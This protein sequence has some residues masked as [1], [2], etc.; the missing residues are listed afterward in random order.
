MVMMTGMIW[1][2]R[3]NKVAP[4]GKS[5]ENYNPAKTRSDP[6]RSNREMGA[7]KTST[8]QELRRRSPPS[9]KIVAAQATEAT[10]GAAATLATARTTATTLLAERKFAQTPDMPA[11]RRAGHILQEVHMKINRCS[12]PSSSKTNT[13]SIYTRQNASLT[14]QPRRRNPLTRSDT[15]VNASAEPD[16]RSTFTYSGI[17]TQQKVNK[18]KQRRRFHQNSCCC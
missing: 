9:N 10:R 14:E 8:R 4:V 1:D 17:G 18:L 6:T 15:A 16:I 3:Q 11:T 13:P 7:K 12:P 5:R 2:T